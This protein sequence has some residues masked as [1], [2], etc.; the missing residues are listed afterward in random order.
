MKQHD[1]IDLYIVLENGLTKTENE[2][3]PTQRQVDD[4]EEMEDG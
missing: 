3:S 4:E 2:R 1:S